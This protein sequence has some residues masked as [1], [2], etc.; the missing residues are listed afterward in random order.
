MYR[1]WL[2]DY[3]VTVSS[4]IVPVRVIENNN[5]IPSSPEEEFNP[6]D[7]GKCISDNELSDVNA[8]YI[9][10]KSPQ[11]SRQG[12]L[13]RLSEG[14]EDEIMDNLEWYEQHQGEVLKLR[15]LEILNSVFETGKF[16]MKY[17]IEKGYIS[18]Y[19]DY[20]DTDFKKSVR[21]LIETYY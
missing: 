9:Q 1:V 6:I 8:L 7:V 19:I 20:S 10:L 15:A 14:T 3:E 2:A 21:E 5:V 11:T 12:I 17:W 18:H 13:A 16:D 4:S